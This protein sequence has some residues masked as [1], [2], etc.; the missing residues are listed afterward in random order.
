MTIINEETPTDEIK[1]PLKVMGFIVDEI[2]RNVPRKWTFLPK[3][4]ITIT[5]L[6]ILLP[7]L[8]TSG[9]PGIFS[10]DLEYLEQQNVLRHLVIEDALE[11]LNPKFNP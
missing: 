10:T 2:K 1:A 5:E 3:E 9:K 11:I 8:F 6:C 7:F 4:D